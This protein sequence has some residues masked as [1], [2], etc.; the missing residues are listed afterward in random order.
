MESERPEGWGN[1]QAAARAC[2]APPTLRGAGTYS[3]AVLHLGDFDHCTPTAFR[4]ASGTA[5]LWGPPG[6]LP[7]V[8]QVCWARERV[9]LEPVHPPCAVGLLGEDSATIGDVAEREGEVRALWRRPITH[10][11]APWHWLHL[12]ECPLDASS[13]DHGRV[14]LSWHGLYRAGDEANERGIRHADRGEVSRGRGDLNCA[15]R[16][17]CWQAGHG[18][19]R[20]AC[21]RRQRR[22]CSRRKPG[23]RR[24]HRGRCGCVAPA[25]SACCKD[26]HRHNHSGQ[27]DGAVPAHPRSIDLT[28]GESGVGSADWGN[29][30]ASSAPWNAYSPPAGGGRYS[31]AV[32]H[33][34]EFDQ[35]TPTAFSTASGTAALPGPGD[36]RG[37]SRSAGQGKG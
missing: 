25:V 5:G 7:R 21:P 8:G 14:Q 36:N 16:L 27:R 12:T 3:N 37:W 17:F 10:N 2:A 13:R 4:T 31:N 6:E 32:L 1:T 11:H 34:G 24:R 35:V 9:R 23:C 28:G 30:P 18:R 33:F 20:H 29:T 19:R 26:H 15:G 22:S